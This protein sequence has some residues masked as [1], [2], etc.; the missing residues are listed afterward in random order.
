MQK[1]IISASILSANFACLGQEV[2]TILAAGADWIHF[3]VMDN[4][5]VPNLTI[6]PLGCKA[7]RNYG[8]TAFIDVHLMV[9]PVERLLHEFIAAGANMI[10]FHPE[11]SNNVNACLKLIHQAGCKAGLAFNPNT[12]VQLTN[13]QLEYIDLILL[14]TVEPGFAGQPLINKV[15]TKITTTRNLLNTTQKPIR[16][17]VDGGITADNI[18][19]LSNLGADTFIAGS[20]L[21][22]AKDPKAVIENMRAASS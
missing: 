15:L 11:T 4:H 1:T 7:L 10:I 16:L 6:G 17:A 12:S 18:A 5:Y 9:N 14:M 8:I 20:A 19:N 2:T 22:N 21:F 13:Y 3:D